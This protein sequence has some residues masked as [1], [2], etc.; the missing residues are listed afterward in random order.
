[1]AR[2]SFQRGYQT[3]VRAALDAG[4]DRALCGGVGTE[5][6]GDDALWPTAL[7]VQPSR[8]Q[9]R[10]GL[11]LAADMDDLVENVTVL[12]EG[13][14]EVALPAIDGDDDFIETPN[15]PRARR[16]AFQA[17]GIVGPELQR[18]APDCFVG[19]DD[20]AFEQHFLDQAQTERVASAGAT[21]VL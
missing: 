9:A 17:T 16:L 18:P 3:L 5:L 7:F 20:A 6:V 12:I 8:Q 2:G 10:G 15:I 1:M 21:V 13:A 19:D 14:P 11:C 4:H